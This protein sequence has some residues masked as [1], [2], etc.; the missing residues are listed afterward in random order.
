MQSD[1]GHILARPDPQFG[2]RLQSRETTRNRLL[3]HYQFEKKFTNRTSSMY[4]RLA[5]LLS[6]AAMISAILPAEPAKAGGWE[7]VFSV[8]FAGGQLDRN[9]W[10]TRF[11]YNNETLDQFNDEMQR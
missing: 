11:I 3:F 7:L 5:R 1:S 2:S 10:A 9:K 6:A 8:E 4:S